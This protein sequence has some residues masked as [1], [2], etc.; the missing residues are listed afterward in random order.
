MNT[1]MKVGK[2]FVDAMVVGERLRSIDPE[3]VAMLAESIAAIGLQQPISVWSPADGDLNL[4]AG[5]HRFEAYKKLGE[6][7]PD[8]YRWEEIDCVFLDMNDLDRQLWE[9]DENLIRSELSVSERDQHTLRRKELWTQRK[10]QEAIDAVSET[11]GAS[12]PTSL[13]DGRKAGPQHRKSFA[14]ETAEKTRQSKTT[15]NRSLARAKAIAPEIKKLVRR[16]ELDKATY[17]NKLI[18]LTHDEQRA[19]VGSDLEDIAQRRHDHVEKVKAEQ[20]RKKERDE[21]DALGIARFL[22]DRLSPEDF[23]TVRRT[24]SDYHVCMEFLRLREDQL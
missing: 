5:R 4:I 21:N 10:E 2:C 6:K 9:I 14:A 18:K 13:S 17:L 20:A 8:D 24:L 11:G 16:T 23:K 12:C 15:V 1:E 19:K 3:K 22:R 7:N